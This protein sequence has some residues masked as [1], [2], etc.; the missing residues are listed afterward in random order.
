MSSVALLIGDHTIMSCSLMSTYFCSFFICGNIV[1]CRSLQAKQGVCLRIVRVSDSKSLV[2]VSDVWTTR[3]SDNFLVEVCRIKLD[4]YSLLTLSGSGLALVDCSAS[5]KTISVLNEWWILTVALSLQIRIHCRCWLP[6]IASLN[7]ILSS[8]DPVH[9]IIGSL[10]GTLGYEMSEVEDGKLFSQV[11]KSAES[12]GYTEPDPRDDFSGMDV[13]RKALILS[14]L[15]GQGS[16]M[17]SIKIESLYPEAMG[18][19]VMAVDEFLGNVSLLDKDIQERVH[20]ASLKGNVLRYVC[21]IEGSIGQPLV[22]QA[23]GA[24]NDTM[25]CGVLAD[26]IN[27]W[28]LFP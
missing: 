5:S 2:V 20:K 3:L 8:G 26:I 17:N 22:I 24:G 11:V 21:V 25:V 23:A 19:N 15:L 4:G 18:P 28:D 27:M 6:V 13:A 1:S 10:S 14:R 7:H 9:R 16:N 12:L